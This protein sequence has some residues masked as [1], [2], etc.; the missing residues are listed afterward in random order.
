MNATDFGFFSSQVIV[1]IRR[2]AAV[3][4]VGLRGAV[5]RFGR[6]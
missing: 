6:G 1:K 4:A 5:F 2:R 3:H